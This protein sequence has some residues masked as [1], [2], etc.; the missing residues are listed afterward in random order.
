MKEYSILFSA[1]ILFIH[2]AY[3]AIFFG[4]VIFDEKYIRNFSIL[5]QLGV[6]LFLIVRFFPHYKTHVLTSFD[7]TIIFYCA[8]FLLLNVVATEVY[9][10]FFQGTILDNYIQSIK[11]QIIPIDTMIQN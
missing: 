2:A 1:S 8:T 3:L 5:I 11:N 6:C 10:A 9:V 4:L 7:V